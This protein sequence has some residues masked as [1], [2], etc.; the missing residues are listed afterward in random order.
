MQAKFT[1]W[2]N[3]AKAHDK[4]LLE[5]IAELK[6]FLPE[7]EIAESDKLFQEKTGL[8]PAKCG[9]VGCTVEEIP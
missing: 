2:D 8:N 6:P 4:K 3:K 5:V 7:A 9:W 1:Y